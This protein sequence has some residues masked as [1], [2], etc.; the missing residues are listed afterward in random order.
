M[1]E[2]VLTGLLF[3]LL[4]LL[5]SFNS[6]LSFVVSILLFVA[7]VR[8]SVEIEGVLPVDHTSTIKSVRAYKN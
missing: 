2:I 3:R 6:G 4:N 1:I 8:D 5:T 7:L